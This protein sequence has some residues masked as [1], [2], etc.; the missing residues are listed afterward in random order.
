MK[1]A[2]HPP[3]SRHLA[4]SD[5]YVF[6]HVNGCLEA[7]SFESAD[8]LLEAP[9]RAMD[10]IKKEDLQPVFLEWMDRLRKCIATDGEYTD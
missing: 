1:T 8:K 9:Q 6:V 2:V 3:Y 4:P 7:L 10:S 5:L